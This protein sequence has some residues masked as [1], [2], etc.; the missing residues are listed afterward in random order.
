MCIHEEHRQVQQ[1]SCMLTT[2]MHVL[3]VTLKNT[4]VKS[5]APPF[6]KVRVKEQFLP[7]RHEG[8]IQHSILPFRVS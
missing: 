4:L 3:S 8:K 5:V 2:I 1:G 6:L 7:A